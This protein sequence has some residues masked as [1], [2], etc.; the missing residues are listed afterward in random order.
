MWVCTLAA[1]EPGKIAPPPVSAPPVYTQD[2]C[3]AL[4]DALPDRG[5]AEVSFVRSATLDTDGTI[6]IEAWV[7]S[8]ERPT[9]QQL[10]AWLGRSGFPRHRRPTRWQTATVH[11]FEAS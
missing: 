1:K 4:L 5:A 7:F 6:R 3:R 8:D 10:Q 9:D 11:Y 2:D